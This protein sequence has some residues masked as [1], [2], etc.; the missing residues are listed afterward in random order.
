MQ[1]MNSNY[2][3]AILMA[4]HNRKEKTL[5][6]LRNL[7][8]CALPENHKLHIFLVDDGSTDGTAENVRENF[9]QVKIIQG[10]GHLF[11]N[12][13]MHLAWKCASKDCDY[14]FYLWLNDDT[15]LYVNSLSELLEV[16]QSKN[17]EAIICGTACAVNDKKSITYGG[18]GNSADV[19]IRPLIPN[20][21]EQ[22]CECFNGN[23]VLIPKIVFDKIGFNDSFY[24][25]SSGD[26]DYGLM[27][28]K[29]GIK[30]YVSPSILGECEG[31]LEKIPIWDNLKYP[32][33]KRWQNLHSPFGLNPR[34][35]FYFNKKHFGILFAIRRYISIYVRV[36]FL[37][38][39]KKYKG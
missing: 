37:R 32:L 8:A 16:S 6:C 17:N 22:E 36:L 7:F 2:N 26:I 5:C 9:P 34:E 14:D 24:T 21:K 25:H 11:W 27:A 35:L 28:E 3:I 30:S 4:C 18:Y 13:G 15:N 38:W 29:N 12:R 31:H 39:W 19:M 33:K 20:G 10:N 23:I 1:N